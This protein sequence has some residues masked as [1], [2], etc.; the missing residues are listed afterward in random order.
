MGAKVRRLGSGLEAGDMLES[1]TNTIPTIDKYEL[2][3]FI[4]ISYDIIN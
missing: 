3:Y 2:G 1:A 4:S